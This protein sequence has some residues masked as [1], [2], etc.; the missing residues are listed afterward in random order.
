MN[1]ITPILLAL[2]A[3]VLLI[4]F[5]YWL[6]GRTK[7]APAAQAAPAPA[8]LSREEAVDHLRALRSE[9]ETDGEFGQ[10]QALLLFDCCAFLGFDEGEVQAVIGAA[11]FDAI[12][13]P[14]DL[15]L[16]EEN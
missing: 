9:L 1:P 8:W 7:T 5:G 13:E 11:W 12:E 4:L 14:A 15:D 2:T 16:E 3:A 10:A 6:R